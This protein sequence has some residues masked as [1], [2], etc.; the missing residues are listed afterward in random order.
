MLTGQAS[1][2]LR[3]I[4]SASLAASSARLR[5][6]M[7][8]A[9]DHEPAFAGRAVRDEVPAAVGMLE[10][11][12]AEL[13]A[14]PGPFGQPFVDLAGRHGKLVALRRH[15][16]EVEPVHAWRQ[17][18][19]ADGVHLAVAAVGQDQAIVPVVKR[20][21]LRQATR[22]RRSA[23]R[24]LAGS[25]PGQRSVS[26]MFVVLETITCFP[27]KSIRRAEMRTPEDAVRRRR[28]SARGNRRHG[29]FRCKRIDQCLSIGP[30]RRSG[31]RLSRSPY[32]SWL[33]G[34]R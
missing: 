26:L 30:C 22:S 6:V 15:A 1:R 7:S 21:A 20:E 16:Q 12:L 31:P 11:L 23:G 14:V 18:V 32:S 29:R 2:T 13:A 33:A 27:W 8:S 9:G 24:W 28:T 19:G 4:S 34:L 3:T 10:F 5:S 25:A 17:D